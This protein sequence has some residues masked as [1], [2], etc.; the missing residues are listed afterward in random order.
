MQAR[1]GEIERLQDARDAATGQINLMGVNDET[2]RRLSERERERAGE[3][4]QVDSPNAAGMVEAK[5]S[6]Y[7]SFC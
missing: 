7:G 1:L 2:P 6:N 3:K 4:H 5:A